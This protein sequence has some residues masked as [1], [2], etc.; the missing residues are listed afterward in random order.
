MARLPPRTGLPG[1]ASRPRAV[2]RSEPPAGPAP[3]RARRR[4]RRPRE[5]RTQPMRPSPSHRWPPAPAARSL[6]CS[7]LAAGGA[8]PWL[9]VAGRAIFLAAACVTG[10]A[11]FLELASVAVTGLAFFRHLARVWP[12]RLAASPGR[13]ASGASR[14]GGTELVVVSL[15]LPQ[16]HPV[17]GI[18]HAWLERNE[19]L[20]LGPD[21]VLAAVVGEL[22]LVGHGQR[23]GRACLDAQ[24]T[25]NALLQPVRPP[26]ELVTAVETRRRRARLLRVL[27]GVNFPEHLAERDSEPLHGV[28]EVK[29]Q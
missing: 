2:P 17:R 26:V 12:A 9:T 21:Q 6:P 3:C 27:D 22:I 13:A 10:Q 15:R 4:P 23:A 16:A 28:Q 24:P 8:R 29:H 20:F 1:R 25:A 14:G 11:I 5:P 19:E 7:V 18:L